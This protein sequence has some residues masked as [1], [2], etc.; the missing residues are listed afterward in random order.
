M[1]GAVRAPLRTCCRRSGADGLRREARQTAR[2]YHSARSVQACRLEPAGAGIRL[3]RRQGAAEQPQG[4]DPSAREEHTGSVMP[5][6]IATTISTTITSAVARRPRQDGVASGPARDP[7]RSDAMGARGREGVL[8]L[9][10]RTC[11]RATL[12]VTG[13][14]LASRWGIGRPAGG[15]G[16]A[17]TVRGE[18][19]R[20]VGRAY[21]AAHPEEDPL[22]LED[23]SLRSARRFFRQRE[24]DYR[25]RRTVLVH[26]WVLSRAECRL[27]ALVALT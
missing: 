20:R 11:L 1:P 21:L 19:A 12:L 23:P 10:R 9:T 15:P 16:V 5:R 25:E 3:C 4:E 18:A 22:V 14:L 27:C 7:D 13:V 2:C 24:L 17:W 6:G 26:G 8:A